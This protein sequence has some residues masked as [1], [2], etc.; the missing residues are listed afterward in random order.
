MGDKFTDRNG[1][2]RLDGTFAGGLDDTAITG[3][4]SVSGTD[5]N[6]TTVTVTEATGTSAAGT[7]ALNVFSE[8]GVTSIFTLDPY[9]TLALRADTIDVTNGGGALQL[10]DHT[11]RTRFYL[12]SDD[13]SGTAT[14]VAQALILANPQTGDLLGFYGVS[15]TQQAHIAD[16]AGGGTVDAQSRTAIVAILDALEAYGLLKTS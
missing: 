2:L 4:L 10:L 13:G 3:T 12:I 7:D 14:P 16:P 11:A 1:V 9:G 15:A 8:D 5:A 6:A